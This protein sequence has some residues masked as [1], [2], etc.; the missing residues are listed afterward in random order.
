MKRNSNNTNEFE[1]K[2][3]MIGV[4]AAGLFN[5]TESLMR[6]VLL[7]KPGV[8]FVQ[9]TKA[10]RKNKLDLANYVCFELIRDD[11]DGGGLLTAVHESFHPVCVSDEDGFEILVV[12]AVL[13]ELRVRLIN[14]YG[15]QEGH[16]EEHR[17]GF[18]H[19]LDLEIKKAQL[20]GCLICI[21]MDSNAKLGPAIIPGDPHPQS[22][23]GKPLNKVVGE[24][25]L[26]VVNGKDVCQ[27]VITRLRETVNGCEK[28]VIDHFIVC[29]R[30][31]ELINGMEVDEAGK[32]ALTS[33]CNKAGKKTVIKESDHKTMIL[34]VM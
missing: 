20:A 32:H 11:S 22:E 2:L 24:N 5:K 18:Y 12:E 26:V 33:Y 3:F 15:P 7:F 23:N 31:F 14:G 9:E 19:Q 29:R 1:Q 8:V 16:S 30:M 21:E 25:D 13:N 6:I 28:S 27:G 4:N 10:R 17:K 34:E